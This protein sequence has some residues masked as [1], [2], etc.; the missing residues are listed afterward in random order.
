VWYQMNA[1]CMRWFLV[2]L[3]LFLIFAAILSGP[4]TI[5][6]SVTWS[7][8]DYRF[9]GGTDPW[10]LIFAALIFASYLTL[11]M[12]EPAESGEALPGVFRRFVAFWIDFVLAMLV[13][14]PVF[15][16]LVAL[17]E[18]QRTGAFQ[19]FFE[20]G[21]PAPGDLSLS[22]VGSL[23]IFVVL[24]FY[25]AIPL[26]R[27]RPSPGACIT[28]YQVVSDEDGALALGEAMRRTMLG[29]FA[30]CVWPLT[31]FIARDRKR[32]KIWPDRACRTRA[33]LLG[34]G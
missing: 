21:T 6:A 34:R 32:G 3:L 10:S 9:A 26:T 5:G 13:C 24:A 27:R 30:L 25:Y 20:R 16:I 22:I 15:G 1:R 19:W 33:V 8:G 2:G 23:V 11:M 18:W 31:L 17:R 28:G 4:K 14:A 29:I 7:D 12:A